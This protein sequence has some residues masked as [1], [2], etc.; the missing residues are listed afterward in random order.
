MFFVFGREI[1]W[2]CIDVYV[3]R[4]F[5][6]RVCLEGVRATP[7]V[8]NSVGTQL[9]RRKAPALQNL[10]AGRQWQRRCSAPPEW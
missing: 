1:G 5:H 6:V 7:R 10:T 2:V 3:C 8:G 9:A 4:E